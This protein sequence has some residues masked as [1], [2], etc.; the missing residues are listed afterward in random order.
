MGC[1][2]W[3]YSSEE[4]LKKQLDCGLHDSFRYG[5]YDSGIV[6]KSM[7]ETIRFIYDEKNNCEVFD[8]TL[9]EVVN[10][11]LKYPDGRIEFG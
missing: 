9:N 11:W 2:T 6:L 5:K 3:F 7:D 4:N 1:H 10:F 8:S